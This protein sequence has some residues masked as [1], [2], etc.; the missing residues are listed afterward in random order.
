L[1][2]LLKKWDYTTVIHEIEEIITKDGNL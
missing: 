1:K 2:E